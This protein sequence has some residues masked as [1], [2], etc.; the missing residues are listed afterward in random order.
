MTVPYSPLTTECTSSR[1]ADDDHSFRHTFETKTQDGQTFAITVLV[2]WAMRWDY[3]NSSRFDRTSGRHWTTIRNALQHS[4][5]QIGQNA[6]RE[7]FE[8]FLEAIVLDW[9]YCA[10]RILKDDGFTIFRFRSEP[11]IFEDSRKEIVI[12]IDDG[13]TVATLKGQNTFATGR[14]PDVAIGRL[15]RNHP[16]LFG[17]VVDLGQSVPE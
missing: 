14:N 13:E 11:P 9:R 8:N 7:Q 4:L 6:T 15:I 17:I 5:F 1:V 2:H 16:E 10:N 3:Y 12:T